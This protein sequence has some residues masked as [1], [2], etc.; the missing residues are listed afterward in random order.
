[1]IKLKEDR[2]FTCPCTGILLKPT[3]YTLVCEVKMAYTLV[4]EE[5]IKLKISGGGILPVE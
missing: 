3:D 4:Y 1:M 2:D 5:T